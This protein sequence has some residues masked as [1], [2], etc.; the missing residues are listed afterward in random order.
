V[1]EDDPGAAM[2]MRMLEVGL[3]LDGRRSLPPSAS[4]AATSI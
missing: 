4:Y 2:V 1:T 3:L